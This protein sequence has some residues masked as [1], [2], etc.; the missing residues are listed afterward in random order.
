MTDGGAK[1]KN[2]HPDSKNCNIGLWPPNQSSIL[3]SGKKNL[4]QSTAH[5]QCFQQCCQELDRLR[6]VHSA[7]SNFH[8]LNQFEICSRPLQNVI[9]PMQELLSGEISYSF[10][11]WAFQHTCNYS[12]T[13]WFVCLCKFIVHGELQKKMVAKW[14]ILTSV[15]IHPVERLDP[16][17]NLTGPLL[18]RFYPIILC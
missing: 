5:S 7:S 6:T 3:S 14:E 4:R 2:K 15:H 17:Q 18:E 12:G 9:S 11:P 8:V 16:N 1:S 13:K 10:P